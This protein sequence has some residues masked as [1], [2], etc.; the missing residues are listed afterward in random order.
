MKYRNR[1]RLFSAIYDFGTHIKLNFS[2]YRITYRFGRSLTP[3]WLRSVNIS[4][5]GYCKNKKNS[6]FYDIFGA[7][8]AYLA[9]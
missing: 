8:Y 9:K 2:R 5:R 6:A 7:K 3:V 1:A 4:M